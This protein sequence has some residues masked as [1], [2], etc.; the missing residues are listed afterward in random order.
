MWK[1]PES[2]M[3]YAQCSA[4]QMLAHGSSCSIHT[5]AH[6]PRILVNLMDY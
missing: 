6:F 2:R 3:L 4:P 5:F 1:Y